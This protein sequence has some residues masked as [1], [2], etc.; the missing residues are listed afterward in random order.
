LA[1]LAALLALLPNGCNSHQQ[2]FYDDKEGFHFTPPPGWVERARGDAL[3]SKSG[4]RQQE[5][6]LP[7][8]GVPGSSA[9]ERLLVRYDRL[10]AGHLAWLRVTAADLPASTTL[11]ACVS[12]RSPGSNWKREAEVETLEVSGRPAARIAFVG[13]YDNQEYLSETVA[14][15]QGDRVYFITASFPASDAKAREQV[16]KAVAE[17]TWK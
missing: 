15:R 11:Q 2:P 16:R 17:A 6:P 13:R 3:P 4:H 10:T 5:L 1:G 8:L 9:Q 12:S 14:G 7:K